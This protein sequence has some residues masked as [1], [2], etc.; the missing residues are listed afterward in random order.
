MAFSWTC[1]FLL[2][3]FQLFFSASETLIDV[4]GWYEEALSLVQM[5]AGHRPLDGRTRALPGLHQFQVAV[6]EGDNYTP[7]ALDSTNQTCDG[8]AT[9]WG[10][11]GHMMEADTIEH[12]ALLCSAEQRC[13]FVQYQPTHV[14]CHLY[15]DCETTRSCDR[16]CARTLARQIDSGSLFNETESPSTNT[17][18][19]SSSFNSSGSIARKVWTE[20][21]T[22]G[23]ITE[24]VTS[25][26]PSPSAPAEPNQEIDRRQQI[27]DDL[28][29]AKQTEKLR[30]FQSWLVEAKLAQKIAEEWQVY[31]ELVGDERLKH[32][33]DRMHEAEL[34]MNM[35]KLKRDLEE[36]LAIARIEKW[37]EEVEDAQEDLLEHQLGNAETPEVARSLATELEK[38]E[39]QER[40]EEAEDQAAMKRTQK[41]IDLITVEIGETK[42]SLETMVLQNGLEEMTAK[43]KVKKAHATVKKYEKDLKAQKL[44]DDMEEAT[45][46]ERAED[47]QAQLD[48]ADAEETVDD[49]QKDLKEAKTEAGAAAWKNEQTDMQD[50]QG[51]NYV[52]T[53][54]DNTDETCDGS[55]TF[56]GRKGQMSKTPSLEECAKLCSQEVQCRFI[57][58]QAAHSTC[59]MYKDCELTRSCDN[60]CA[61]T[62]AKESVGLSPVPQAEFLANAIS[63]GSPRN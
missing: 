58:F 2:L 9:A 47:L 18:R 60:K 51:D 33:G 57:Q 37:K 27:E 32:Y 34:R 5:R 30:K 50:S 4:A 31:E 41:R 42:A 38:M 54:Q 25:S 6:R 29:L 55:A 11:K 59:H 46:S 63:S 15:E 13:R 53:E 20:Q 7:T 17:N 44:Q 62:L 39:T 49:L 48:D 35:Q 40:N 52:P 61:R 36:Q 43:E 3:S 26:T 16:S 23:S 14:V 28:A 21:E 10:R 45:A 22:E 12:C 1:C 56:W 19:S 24:P 8:T